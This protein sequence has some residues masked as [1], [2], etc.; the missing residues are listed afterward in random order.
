M[1]HFIGVNTNS[2][3]KKISD[4]IIQYIILKIT[5]WHPYIYAIDYPKLI[6]SNQKG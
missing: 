3:G 4:K 1:L 6:L 5:A 2:E